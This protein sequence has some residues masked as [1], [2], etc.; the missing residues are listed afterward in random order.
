MNLIERIFDEMP[1]R[2]IVGTAERPGTYYFSVGPHKYTV[3]ITPESCT[4]E[5]GKV[6][7]RADC[8]LKT[9]PELFEKMVIRGKLP[10][11]FDIMKGKVKTND[12]IALKKL[13]TMFD[14]T[15]L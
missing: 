4:V 12:P 6:D 5:P 15:G 13:R 14:L 11:P 8:V 3:R 1:R 2:Y 10:G 9:T 7:D